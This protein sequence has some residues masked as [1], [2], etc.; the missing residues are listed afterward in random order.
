MFNPH[1]QC[2]GLVF[3][4]FYTNFA[5]AQDRDKEFAEQYLRV[6]ATDRLHG[7]D[8][9]EDQKRDPRLSVQD[10]MLTCPEPKEIVANQ[11]SHSWKT[12]SI[13][14]W[15]QPYLSDPIMDSIEFD[16]VQIIKEEKKIECRYKWDD[17]FSDMEPY[18]WASVQFDLDMTTNKTFS[19]IRNKIVKIE[20]LPSRQNWQK[21]R[22]QGMESIQCTSSKVHDCLFYISYAVKY[23]SR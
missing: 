20:I 16:Q 2:F 21:T 5:L 3:I 8:R 1:F 18:P 11:V 13:Y 17:T 15:T 22:S 4:T 6:L 14:Y 10:L 9:P 19:K 12:Q 23:P 7:P